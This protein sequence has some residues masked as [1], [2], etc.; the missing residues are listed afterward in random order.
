L[1]R[2]N[3]QLKIL[4]NLLIV[5]TPAFNEGR[6]KPLADVVAEQLR[7][8]SSIVLIVPRLHPAENKL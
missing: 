8:K 1:V 6:R 5:D 2:K 7:K 4:G 3:R